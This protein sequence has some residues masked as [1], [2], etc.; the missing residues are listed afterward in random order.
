MT[1]TEISTIA[2]AATTGVMLALYWYSMTKKK[3]LELTV[4]FDHL[5][6]RV[7]EGIRSAREDIRNIELSAREDIRNIERHIDTM[8]QRCSR[9]ANNC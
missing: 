3:E 4:R 5:E 6:Q 7:F 9:N 2:F 1:V 8:E